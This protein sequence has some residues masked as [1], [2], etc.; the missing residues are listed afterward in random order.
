MA[1]LDWTAI[2]TLLMKYLKIHPKSPFS[3]LFFL[4]SSHLISLD[5][6]YTHLFNSFAFPGRNPHAFFV[7]SSPVSYSELAEFVVSKDSFGS[8]PSL[9]HREPLVNH[10]E[11]LTAAIKY[12]A[13]HCC[14]DLIL[15]FRLQP[16]LASLWRS[17]LEKDM[18]ASNSLRTILDL[19]PH[20]FHGAKISKDTYS[21]VWKQDLPRYLTFVR[22]I[23]L[24]PFSASSLPPSLFL[25]LVHP[26]IS[27]VLPLYLAPRS[28]PLLVDSFSILPFLQLSEPSPSPVLVSIGVKFFQQERAVVLTLL[29]AR[30]HQLLRNAIDLGFL[31]PP[32]AADAALIIG[33]APILRILKE[34]CNMLPSPEQVRNWFDNHPHAEGESEADH[35]V[36]LALEEL[37][38]KT[39]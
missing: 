8:L 33:S 15:K 4:L 31:V 23:L 36:R 9:N 28:P 14:K 18:P 34:K 19:F 3:G 16:D 30:H 6:I 27:P 35:D 38:P 32:A 17:F 25:P 13:V 21:Y 11:V 12:R 39:L 7:V 5:L 10:P 22:P 26:F 37:A 24:S 1:S 29:K 20:E 2:G